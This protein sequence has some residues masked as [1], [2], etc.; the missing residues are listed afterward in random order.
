MKRTRGTGSPAD[1]EHIVG[2]AL[3]AFGQGAGDVR[4]SPPA[5]ESFRNQFIH[6][7][8]LAL[9][10]PGW[11]ADWRREKA[12]LLAYAEAMGQRAAELAAE[13]GRPFITHQDVTFATT[14]LRGYM[15][16]AGRWC[17]L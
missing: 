6:K 7:I 10:K 4:M 17:P 5:I 13:E 14:K 12:Y 2:A 1:A 11:Q 8:C 15:P 3:S 9:E 16:V